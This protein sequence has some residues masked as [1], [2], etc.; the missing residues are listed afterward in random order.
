MNGPRKSDR[1]MVPKKPSNKAGQPA[2]E[3]AEGRGLAEG[4]V[5]QQNAQRTQ[6]RTSAPSALDRVRQAARKDKKKQFTALLHH[7]TIDRLR[8]AF[9]ALEP[10]AAA[11]VDG[12]T[13][14]QYREGLDKKL[15]DLHVKLHRGAYR[16]RPTRRAYIP[17]AD[18]KMRALGIAALED[19]MVQR[20]VVEVMNAVHETDFLG[21]SYGF[22]TGRSQHNALDALAT[23]ILHKKVNW[24]LD[25]DIRGFFDAIDHGWL[26]KFVGHRIADRRVLRLIQKWLSAGVIEEGR[27]TECEEGAP[28]GATVS[29]LLA[30][31]YLHYGLDIWVQQ[32]RKR[33]ARG[34]MIFVRYADDF[35]VGFQ[36]QDDAERFR[37]DLAERL[38]RFKLELHPDKTRL[39]EFGRYAAERRAARGEGKPETFDFLGFTHICASRRAGGFLLARHTSTKRMRR[40]LHEIREDLHGRRHTPVHEQG[41]WLGSVLRGYFAYHA[42]HTNIQALQ[43]FRQQ[44]ERHWLHALRRR[45]QRDRTDW[46]RLRALSERWLPAAEISHPWPDDRF[47]ARTLG[48]SPVR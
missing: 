19:K 8:T 5:D 27:W 2:A 23:G 48:R 47:N 14:Q 38:G 25:A 24:V 33:Q 45:G 40:R 35:I 32:W 36:H 42:V 3:A 30:N 21:F 13:W 11:G 4:N 29:P 41:K 34:E 9:E 26:M 43:T 46:K 10:K 16:A 28:Q 18:G 31:I 44:V 22:R 20:A 17:K 15:V 12:V 6:S 1:P 37:R 39:I 7:V